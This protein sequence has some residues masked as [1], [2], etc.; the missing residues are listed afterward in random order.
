MDDSTRR[1]ALRPE[2]GFQR[3][4]PTD[5]RRPLMGMVVPAPIGAETERQGDVGWIRRVH[6]HHRIKPRRLLAV[7]T[8]PRSHWPIPSTLIPIVIDRDDV[9]AFGA[10]G[11]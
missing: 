10:R 5:R 1:S 8:L 11:R 4:G 2:E 6:I 3:P 9:S 7:A